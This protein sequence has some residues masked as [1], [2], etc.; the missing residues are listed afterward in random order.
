LTE[1]LAC[2]KKPESSMPMDLIFLQERR[3]R[4]ALSSEG[5]GVFFRQGHLIYPAG[6]S[7]LAWRIASGAVRLDSPGSVGTPS[8]ALP[9]ALI[10]IENLFGKCN[11]FTACAVADSWLYPLSS[12][13]EHREPGRYH[14]LSL[15]LVEMQFVKQHLLHSGHAKQRINRLLGLLGLC[16]LDDYAKLPS[17][18]D[19]AELTCLKYS[20]VARVLTQAASAPH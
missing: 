9:G 13:Q 10:G 12:A 17:I 1:V 18:R 16:L 8:L 2:A 19:I 20:A 3:Q 7:G 6:V 4:L 15:E 11:S 5:A 14:Q